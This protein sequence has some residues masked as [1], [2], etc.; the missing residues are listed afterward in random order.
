MLHV[1][2]HAYD[3]PLMEKHHMLHVHLI[4]LIYAPKYAYYNILKTYIVHNSPFTL[5]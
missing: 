3:Y 5:C 2:A 1:L 4:N